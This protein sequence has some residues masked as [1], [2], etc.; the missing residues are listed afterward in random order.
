[1]TKRH[2]SC[3]FLLIISITFLVS[4]SESPRENHVISGWTMGTY[5]KVTL[6]QITPDQADSA[7]KKISNLLD[8]VNQ[9]MSV[10]D[11]DSE[12]SRFNDIPAG[13][14]LC[15]S[16]DFAKVMRIC[17]KVYEMT[18]KL[19]DPS[20]GSLIELWG[21][22]TDMNI[23]N[24][25]DQNQISKVMADVGL[26]KISMDEK[27]CL[28]K[29]RHN[30]RLNLSAVAKGYAVDLIARAMEELNIR[31]YLVDIGGDMYAGDAKSDGSAWNIGISAPLP[32]AGAD[33]YIET[34]EIIN[35][36]VATSGDYRNYFIKNNQKYSHIIDP[37][38]GYPV[39]QNIVSATVK[40]DNCA[41][42]DALATAMLVMD[43]DQALQLSAESELFEVL[44]MQ[45][46]KN[47]E[48]SIHSSPGFN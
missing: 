27:N 34:V 33:D 24:L 19:F 32:Q 35:H 26:D 17:F 29:S 9:S 46:D 11:P 1:M 48:I 38:T 37:T 8:K 12:V 20:A 22:G 40:A 42:A 4:C 21:F 47:G 3:Y 30:I 25:P 44:L 23:Q 6:L 28:T 41:L 14:K 13:R 18:D 43:K 10:F 36:A 45:M 39:R 5:Y 7:Q 16:A 15:V 2:F 31:S